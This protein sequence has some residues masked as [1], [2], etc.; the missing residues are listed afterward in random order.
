MIEQVPGWAERI[1]FS[2]CF[3]VEVHQVRSYWPANIVSSQLAQ[4]L[5]LN[6][7]HR[8]PPVI[9]IPTDLRSGATT[10]TTCQV[11][12]SRD[13]CASIL[14]NEMRSNAF[15]VLCRRHKLQSPPSIDE[16]LLNTFVLHPSFEYYL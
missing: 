4:V 1:V 15:I 12:A 9:L 8:G 13:M 14:V 3:G 7:A 2:N 6:D 16:W 5:K 10:I 11:L